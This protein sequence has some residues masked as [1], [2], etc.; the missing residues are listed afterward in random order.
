[1]SKEKLGHTV[2]EWKMKM[3]DMCGTYCRY[4]R[5]EV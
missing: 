5:E 3:R 2:F 1:M 4:R